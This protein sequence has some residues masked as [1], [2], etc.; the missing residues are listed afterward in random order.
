M[1]NKIE[2]QYLSYLESFDA[3]YRGVL[4]YRTK[5]KVEALDRELL[6][7]G[8]VMKE[9]NGIREF[10]NGEQSPNQGALSEI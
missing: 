4:H 8:D 5:V 10:R 9:C 1:L 3:N 6:L 2:L 7:L